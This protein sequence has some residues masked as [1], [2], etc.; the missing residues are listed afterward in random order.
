[1]L[2]KIPE[3]EVRAITRAGFEAVIDPNALAALA[4]L[5]GFKQRGVM[6]T[7]LLCAYDPVRYGV[8]DRWALKGLTTLGRGVGRSLGMTV[9]YLEVVRALRDELRTTRPSTTARD[10]DKAL[11]MLG[12]QA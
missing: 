4:S 2:L 12:K 3:V 7:A 6:S 1:M 9:R 10:I 8:M 11:F 5:P